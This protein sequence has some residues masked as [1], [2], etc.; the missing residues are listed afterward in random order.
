MCK[1]ISFKLVQRVTKML[2]QINAKVDILQLPRKRVQNI[3]AIIADEEE[4]NEEGL[5]TL[6]EKAYN[7]ISDVRKVIG[8]TLYTTE[9]TTDDMKNYD[10]DSFNAPCWETKSAKFRILFE[11][12]KENQDKMNSLQLNIKENENA[13]S[14]IKEELKNKQQTILILTE[15]NIKEKEKSI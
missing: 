4:Q 15:Q 7:I 5:I 8:S 6:L 9:Q 12:Q 10:Y 14:S 2:E 1:H 3:N 11:Q 13:V